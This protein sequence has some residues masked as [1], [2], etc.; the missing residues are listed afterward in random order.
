MAF[1][2]HYLAP[3]DEFERA[4]Q[5][6]YSHGFEEIYALKNV[7]IRSIRKIEASPPPKKVNSK[8]ISR[9]C[10]SPLFEQLELPFGSPFQTKVDL[11][12]YKEP[13]QVVGFSKRVE[14]WLLSLGKRFIGDLLDD[15]R[16]SILDLK[17]IGQGHLDEVNE[18]LQWYLEEHLI[19]DAPQKF[20]SVSWLKTLVGDLESK[21]C[22]VLMNAF[23]LPLLLPLTPAENAEVR[24]LSIEN[25]NLWVEDALALCRLPTKIE[26]AKADMQQLAQTL[27]KPWLQKRTGIAREEEL[28]ECLLKLSSFYPHLD[29]TLDFVSKAFFEDA[30]ILSASLNPVEEELYCNSPETAQ[31]FHEVI[32]T[33]RSYFYKDHLHYPLHSLIEWVSR[34]LATKWQGFEDAFI[35]RALRLSSSFRVR[36]GPHEQL[37]VKLS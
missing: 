36:K 34:E 32:E 33:T 7:D 24:K 3:L 10:K 23:Q 21:K 18:K 11:F 20:N 27:I 22:A 19:E 37:T 29:Q 31:A 17:G 2:R 30:F 15:K 25:R 14:S 13:L 1:S 12:I 6:A 8:K 35:E 16:E 9:K 4:H 28:E 5:S 26:Q